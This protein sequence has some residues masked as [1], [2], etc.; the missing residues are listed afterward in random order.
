MVLLMVVVDIVMVVLVVMVRVVMVV[1]LVERR[2]KRDINYLV[3][4][5]E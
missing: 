1:L 5:L 3:L 4:Y 2:V